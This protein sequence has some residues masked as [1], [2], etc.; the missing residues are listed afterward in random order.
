MKDA[1]ETV[2]DVLYA[3][4]SHSHAWSGVTNKPDSFPPAAHAASHGTGGADAV[5]PASIGACGAPQ[6]VV[7]SLP[8]AGWVLN[9]ATTCYE[10]TV[11]VTGLLAADDQSTVRVEPVGGTDAAAQLLTDEAYGAVFTAGGYVACETAGQMYCRGPAGGDKPGV[12]F[13]VAVCMA[14]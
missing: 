5:T 12:A 14:R 11:P 7:V 13:Q 1:L 4:K 3:A 8:V 2:N 6:R 10:Q 9:A